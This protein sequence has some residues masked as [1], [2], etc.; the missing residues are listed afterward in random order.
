MRLVNLRIIVRYIEVFWA[1]ISMIYH[2]ALAVMMPVREER[3]YTAEGE[4]EEVG[5]YFILLRPRVP[6][7]CGRM[8]QKNRSQT[9]IPRPL[10]TIS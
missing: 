2:E 1:H 6:R 7:L 5:V 3:L 10:F 8:S 9:L 4:A